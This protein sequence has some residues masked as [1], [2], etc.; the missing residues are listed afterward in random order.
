M[1][2][3]FKFRNL[4][5]MSTSK[6]E[7]TVSAGRLSVTGKKPSRLSLSQR[8]LDKGKLCIA[9][10]TSVTSPETPFKLLVE[11]EG[12]G[13]KVPISVP[14]LMNRVVRDFGDKPA[15]NYKNSFGK[16]VTVT[17]RQYQERVEKMAKVFIKLGLERYRTVAVLAFNSPEWFISELAA[18]HAGWV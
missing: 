9:H 18:I 5:K 8:A 7:K 10:K 1:S 4:C 2:S 16:W 11:N 6:L 12:A 15:M 3:D 14:A 17:Y 13:A